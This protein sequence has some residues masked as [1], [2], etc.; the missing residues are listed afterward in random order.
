MKL[1]FSAR[2]CS[3]DPNCQLDMENVA[4]FNQIFFYGT[5][6]IA[7]LIIT[8]VVVFYIILMVRKVVAKGRRLLGMT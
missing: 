4:I 2:I 6:G 8:I 3:L 7:G 5:A 1:V